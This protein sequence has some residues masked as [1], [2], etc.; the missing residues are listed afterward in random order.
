MRVLVIPVNT[1]L[2]PCHFSLSGRMFTVLIFLKYEVE[3]YLININDLKHVY[4][5]TMYAVILS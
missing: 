3:K 4:C 1:V 2:S 5:V